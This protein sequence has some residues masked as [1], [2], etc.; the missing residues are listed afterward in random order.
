MDTY[1]RDH[2]PTEAQAKAGNYRKQH[3]RIAG[4]DV[5]I[6]NPAGTVRRGVDPGGHPWETRMVYDYGYVKGSIGTDG[7]HVDCYLG[8]DAE[9]EY[10]Y[11]I[12]TKAPPDFVKDDEQKCMLGFADEVSA[13][14]AFLHHF[15]DPR[16]FGGVLAMPMDEFRRKVLAADGE[17]IKARPM[18]LF[19]NPAPSGVAFIKEYRMEK[20][21]LLKSHIEAYTRKD[22][23][24]VGA[25]E[26]SRSHKFGAFHV[27]TGGK[28]GIV[29]TALYGRHEG[30]EYSGDSAVGSTLG[31]HFVKVMKRQISV[32]DSLDDAIA[33]AEKRGVEFH[34]DYVAQA[35]KHHQ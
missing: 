27:N 17:M 9:A 4:L 15:D 20:I 2:E 35:K 10:A 26:D 21:D 8:L 31:K 18:I 29:T 1:R 19:F 11:L 23:T 14:A 24:V 16:F 34:P 28:T 33:A 22:G 7:D 3:R 32:H 13:V 30:D 5:S 6:E 25:H 12:T